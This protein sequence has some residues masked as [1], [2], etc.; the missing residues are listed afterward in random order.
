MLWA[1]NGTAYNINVNTAYNIN[2]NNAMHLELPFIIINNE[3]LT[4]QEW[5]IKALWYTQTVVMG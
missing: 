4:S 5:L 2:V 3:L 1:S